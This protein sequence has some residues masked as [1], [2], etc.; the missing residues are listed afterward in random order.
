MPRYDG[1]IPS[2]GVARHLRENPQL[3]TEWR[4]REHWTD[5]DLREHARRAIARRRRHPDYWLR[6]A[7]ETINKW[8]R[9]R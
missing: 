8:L 9:L 3:A 4:S 1:M 5:D 7:K 6:K 2:E